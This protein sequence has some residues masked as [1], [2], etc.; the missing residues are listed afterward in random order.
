M[1]QK[2]SIVLSA[3]LPRATNDEDEIDLRPS[4]PTVDILSNLLGIDVLVGDDRPSSKDRFFDDSNRQVPVA[5]TVDLLIALNSRAALSE[6]DK[7][8]RFHKLRA[9]GL[10]TREG[11][12]HRISG[13]VSYWWKGGGDG[14]VHSSVVAP[15]P[16]ALAAARSLRMKACATPKKN[17]SVPKPEM[18]EPIDEM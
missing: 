4:F 6:N 11:D 14:S 3:H 1:L 15:G 17:T 5:N 13:S 8:S 9:A 18:Y 16:H 10:D 7:R 2:P 12:A